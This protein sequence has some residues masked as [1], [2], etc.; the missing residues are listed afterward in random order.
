MISHEMVYATLIG[1]SAAVNSSGNNETC[2]A[3][4][5]GRKLAR[6]DRSLMAKRL[7]GMMTNR[8]AFSWTCQPNRNDAYPQSVRAPTND[9]QP[10][11]SHSFVRA[12]IWKAS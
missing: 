9:S 3:T 4:A 2:P 11:A 6:Y 7:K 1:N 12:M 5:N 10:G 8:I